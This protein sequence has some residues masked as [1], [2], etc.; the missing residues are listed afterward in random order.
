MPGQGADPIQLHF[1]Q[2]CGISIPAADVESGR[3]PAAPGG[4]HCAACAYQA[5]DEQ[6]QAAPPRAPREGGSR[7]LLAVAMLYVVG[8]ATF[9]L[10]REVQRKPAEVALPSNLASTRDV[11][12]VGRRLAGTEA[13]VKQA[14]GDLRG[15]DERQAALAAEIQKRLVGLE[16]QLATSTQESRAQG[17]E[18]REGV[19]ALAKRSVGLQG[20]VPEILA[21]VRTIERKLEGLG[22]AGDG[23]PAAEAPTAPAPSGDAEEEKRRRQAEEHVAKLLDRSAAEQARYNAAVALGDLKHPYAVDPLIQALEKDSHDL[24]RRAAAWALGQLGKDAVRAI[25]AL[26]LQIGSKEEYIGYQCE[27]ALGDITKAVLGAP[28]SFDFDP[29]MSARDRKKVQKKWEEWWE[30]NKEQLLRE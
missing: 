23:P 16:S 22:G 7:A 26:I 5:R 27:L 18:I 10:V 14:I 8:A 11:E 15:N 6:L 4:F 29:T 30:Q 9:L 28:K 21:L 1:C 20:D 3:A 24:V 19:L 12:E 13:A 2:R 17:D 25:P